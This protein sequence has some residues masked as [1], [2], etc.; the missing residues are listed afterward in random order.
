MTRILVT[1]PEAQNK[2]LLNA[3]Q[4]QGFETDSLPVLSILPY[5]EAEHADQCERI[6]RQVKSLEQ[7]QHV[8]FVSTNAVQ[9]AFKW[10]NQLHKTLPEHIH[11]YPIGDATARELEQFV[12]KVE[13]AGKDMDSETLLLNPLLQSVQGHK[14]LIFRGRGGRNFLHDNLVARGADVEFCE[15]YQRQFVRYPLGALADKLAQS[16]DYLII[17]S[18]ESIQALLEQAIIESLQQPLLEQVIVVPG[19]RVAKFAKEQGFKN[20]VISP[21]AGLDATVETLLQQQ[22]HNKDKRKG[23]SRES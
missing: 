8:V 19:K 14:V 10:I 1:R 16:P 13:Q 7:Y 23:A 6:V 22:K 21:N 18:T 17:T 12:P 5:S 4:Q 11:W 2:P 3:L 9:T 15:I 20:V